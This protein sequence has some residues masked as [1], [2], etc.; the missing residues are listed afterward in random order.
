M[1]YSKIKT[2]LKYLENDELKVAVVFDGLSDVHRII[3]M[4][5]ALEIYKV[6]LQYVCNPLL[7]K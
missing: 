5:T 1:L 2:F 3:T 7:S 4:N 6:K